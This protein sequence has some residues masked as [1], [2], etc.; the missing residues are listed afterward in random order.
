M[1]GDKDGIGRDEATHQ[2]YAGLKWWAEQKGYR[3]ADGWVAFKFKD[4]F[5][6]WPNGEMVEIPREPMEGVVC[7]IVRQNARYAAEMRKQETPEQRK[8]RQLRYLYG[9]SRQ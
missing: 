1:G 5:G 8:E 9:A 3:R 6:R 7:Y 2:V 4:I